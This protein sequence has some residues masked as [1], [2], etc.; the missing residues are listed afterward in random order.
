[1]LQI[2]WLCANLHFPNFGDAQICA[3]PWRR[4]CATS[5]FVCALKYIPRLSREAAA[6]HS[7]YEGGFPPPC[8]PGLSSGGRH[9]ATAFFTTVSSDDLGV[10]VESPRSVRTLARNFSRGRITPAREPLGRPWTAIIVGAAWWHRPRTSSPSCTCA[11]NRRHAV[12]RNRDRGWRSH[13]GFGVAL[14]PVVSPCT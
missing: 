12:R 1:M 5:L 4:I 7:T 10:A 3:S 11:A 9:C 8:K 13:L 14:V 2:Y 6:R